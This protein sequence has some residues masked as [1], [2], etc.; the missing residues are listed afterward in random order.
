MRHRVVAIAILVALGLAVTPLA[1]RAASDPQFMAERGVVTSF[2]G[3]PIVYNLF[4][5]QD[6]SGS[7][8][9]PVILRTHGWGGSGEQASSL[10]GT[11]KAFLQND[12]AVLTWDERG[13]GQSG[14]DAHG[15]DPNME[16][17][18]ASALIDFLAARPEIAQDG[19][20]DPLIGMSG[21]SYAGG[22]QPAL[23]AYDHRVDVIAPEITWNDLR[24]S[25]FPHNVIKFGWDQLLYGAGLATAATDGVTP[26]GTAGIETGAY[27]PGIHES[28]VRGTA[29]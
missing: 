6:A 9:V 23:A 16:G 29:L 1:G 8:R 26:T 17:R 25:L 27:A 10:S 22:I 2:D 19:P 18:D 12:Y 3:T 7:H 15:D 14:G 20:G 13:F 11:S 21:G 5:P 28:E 24:Y 4:E